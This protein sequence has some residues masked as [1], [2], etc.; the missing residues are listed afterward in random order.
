MAAGGGLSRA[1]DSGISPGQGTRP[2]NL[3]K[4]PARLVQAATVLWLEESVCVL[5]G[6]CLVVGQRCPPKAP[7]RRERP[8][9]RPGWNPRGRYPQL[10][11]DR[12]RIPG[13]PLNVQTPGPQAPVQKGWVTP[14]PACLVR[15]LASSFPPTS[16]AAEDPASP[17]HSSW[18]LHLQV[19][20]S[21]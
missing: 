19:L 2:S 20:A 5:G 17:I 16:L 18:P 4:G 21:R 3:A 11:V 15:G 12:V 7:K 13:E 6:R 14:E 9:I 10:G 8:S 1:G